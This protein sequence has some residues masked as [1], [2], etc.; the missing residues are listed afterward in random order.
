MKKVILSLLILFITSISYAGFQEGT[1][2]RKGLLK[3]T[4]WVKV[5]ST[6]P[7]RILD[8]DS[9]RVDSALR[10]TNASYDLM[11]TSWTVIN[12]SWSINRFPQ[13]S[14]FPIKSGEVYSPD[15]FDP[16]E[17]YAI[18]DYGADSTTVKIIEF[19]RQ[20]Y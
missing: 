17:T 13:Q 5:N 14:A 20:E 2:I 3:T 15:G 10:Y 18:M 1:L 7:V 16:G 19:W 8:F 11:I 9:R 4:K 6:Q 12:S